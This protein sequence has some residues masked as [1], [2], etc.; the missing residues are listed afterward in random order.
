MPG[1]PCSSSDALTS[2]EPLAGAATTST[3]AATSNGDCALRVAVTVIGASSA[4]GAVCGAAAAVVASAHVGNS[5]PRRSIRGVGMGRGV[6][7]VR[8]RWR[9]RGVSMVSGWRMPRM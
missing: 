4:C 2:S 1:T 5:R 8:L 9:R 7:S 3:E 6:P